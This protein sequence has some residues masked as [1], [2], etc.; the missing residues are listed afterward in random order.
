M[1]AFALPLFLF[2]GRQTGVEIDLG[3]LADQIRQHKRIRL[4]RIE[5]R[6]ALFREIGFVRFLVDREK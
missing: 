6:A 2:F 5:K 1:L 4:I 3:E